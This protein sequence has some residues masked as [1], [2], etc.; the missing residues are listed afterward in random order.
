MK[1]RIFQNWRSTLLGLAL[2]AIIIIMLFMKIIKAGDFITLL[3]TILGLLYVQ[4][5]IFKINPK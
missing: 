4:D 1:T 3:P 2:L 5:S